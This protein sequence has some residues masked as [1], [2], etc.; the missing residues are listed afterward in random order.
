L[1]TGGPPA[2]GGHIELAAIEPHVVEETIVEGGRAHVTWAGIKEIWTYREVMAT[3]ARRR[4]MV[5]YKQATFGIGWAILQPLLT[6]LIFA[7]FLGRVTRLGSEG[8]PYFGFALTGMVIWTFFSN[9]ALTSMNA[10]VADAF[11]LRKVY[12]PREILPLSSLL[13]GLFDLLPSLA[14]ALIYVVTTTHGPSLAWLALPI[15]ILVAA[16]AGVSLGIGFS[17]INVYYRDVGYIVPFFLQVAL[18]ATPV[19]YSLSQVPEGW[20]VPYSILNP[21]A[22]AADGLRRILLHGRWPDWGI[23]GLALGW[24]LLIGG[25]GYVLFKRLERGFADRI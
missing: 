10:V 24:A 9:L 20:R 8:V 5:R 4:V 11:L 17:G 23:T 15:P 25:L 19:V 6:A 1:V 3:F 2:S 22:P 12:F 14:V 7:I 13:S 18:F 16:V 21:V